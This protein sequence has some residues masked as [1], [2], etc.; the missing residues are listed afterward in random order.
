MV[1]AEKLPKI[2]GD[3]SQ[4][5]Q[6]LL[7]LI[8]NARDAITAKTNIAAQKK[9]TIETAY[10]NLDETYIS[11]HTYVQPGNYVVLGVSDNGIGMDSETRS[12][13][14]EPFYTTKEVGKGTGL[15]LSTVYGIIK[16]N[17]GYINVYSEPGEG[18]TFKVFWPVS[19]GQISSEEK[20]KTEE[21]HASG[22]K[23]I[24]LVEDD[25][26]VR[27]FAETALS[28]RGYHV[29]AKEDGQE[30]F[31]ALKEGKI[32]PKL[33]ITDLIMPKMNGRELAQNVITKLPDCKV[34]YA[35]GYTDNHIVHQGALDKGVNFIQ[36]P[37]SIERLTR[38]VRQILDEL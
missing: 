7:N 28:D 15:G 20:Q 17:D 26:A 18:T 32:N 16:Q 21:L 8:V 27:E 3:P 25:A 30:A 14:F 38:K 19:K 13:I 23:E 6:I 31:Q 24:L 11:E 22:T 4:I 12:K 36:K 37:Y 33:L 5:E 1:P 9:I 34:L 29:L 10:V 35:S 2:Q